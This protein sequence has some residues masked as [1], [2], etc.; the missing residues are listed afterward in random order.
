MDFNEIF[1]VWSELS[2]DNKLF[3][4]RIQSTLQRGKGLLLFC[5]AEIVF[6]VEIVG[7]LTFAAAFSES[8][9]FYPAALVSRSRWKPLPSSISSN[10]WAF[11]LGQR[12]PRWSALSSKSSKQQQS[13]GEVIYLM[14][15]RSSQHPSQ[16]QGSRRVWNYRQR[17][18]RLALLRQRG[19][20]DMTW[21]ARLSLRSFMPHGQLQ[22]TDELLA[23][24]RHRRLLFPATFWQHS[25]CMQIYRKEETK[26]CQ[27]NKFLWIIACIC[28]DIK[29]TDVKAS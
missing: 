15:K 29:F 19:A 21:R 17:S 24:K 2:R 20:A 4:L 28:I 8:L 12:K 1:D 27:K 23:V 16:N 14:Q 10:H 11:T 26:S 22:S 7:I 13:W 9:T 18:D 25:L 6:D 5:R 3:S